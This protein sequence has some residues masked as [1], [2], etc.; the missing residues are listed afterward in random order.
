MIYKNGVQWDGWKTETKSVKPKGNFEFILSDNYKH[1]K[2]VTAGRMVPMYAPLMMIAPTY[3]FQDKDGS[4]CEIR[5]VERE[6]QNFTR[7]TGAKTQVTGKFAPE[8]LEFLDGFLRFPKTKMDLYWFLMNHPDNS[9]NPAYNTEYAR[10]LHA[11]PFIFYFKDK[12][13]EEEQAYRKE[14]LVSEAVVMA[15]SGLTKVEARQVYLILNKSADHNASSR[16][17]DLFLMSFARNNPE[18]FLAATKNDDRKFE[19]SIKEAVAFKVIKY[20][21]AV[22]YWRFVEGDGDGFCPVP[23][24]VNEVKALVEWFRKTDDG[25]TYKSLEERLAAAR[26]AADEE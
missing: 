17:I 21:P 24:G 11:K 2:E 26:T 12:E 22:R 3:E 23:R 6:A 13:L 9:M 1:Y 10:L 18:Q 20:N 15:S 14:K 4:T 8:V 5:Y 19:S 25:S 7:G 16:A